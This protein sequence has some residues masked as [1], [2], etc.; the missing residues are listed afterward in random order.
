M[1]NGG[2]SSAILNLKLEFLSS[3]LLLTAPSCAFEQRKLSSSVIGP[4]KPCLQEKLWL[5]VYCGF[6]GLLLGATRMTA[7][8]LRW[9][10]DGDFLVLRSNR[11]P[12]VSV[13]CVSLTYP[14]LPFSRLPKSKR[15][16]PG[17][18]RILFLLQGFGLCMP[19]KCIHSI[20]FSCEKTRPDLK[21]QSQ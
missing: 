8:V 21:N 5:G 3:G 17:I 15:A 1:P 11:D 10:P 9:G 2:T 7:E 13:L 14:T 19:V 4:M 12:S 16:N 20:P 6:L 18:R